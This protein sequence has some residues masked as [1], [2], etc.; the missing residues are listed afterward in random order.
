LGKGLGVAGELAM[1]AQ[2]GYAI[3]TVTY[4]V[5]PTSMQNTI[6]S[7][8]VSAAAMLGDKEAKAIKEREASLTI[9]VRNHRGAWVDEVKSKGFATKVKADNLGPR[10]HR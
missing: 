1:V 7:W 3:G 9:N 10:M 4:E 6:G 2:T 8:V 5:M